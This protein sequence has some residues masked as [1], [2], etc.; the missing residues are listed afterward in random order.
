MNTVSRFR[1]CSRGVRPFSPTGMF[2]YTD[3]GGPGVGTSDSDAMVKAAAYRIRRREREKER[4]RAA[5][6]E[7]AR[8]WARD[9]AEHLGRTDPTLRKVIGF[10]STFETWRPYRL[11]SDVDLGIVGGDWGLLSRSIPA[12]EFGVSLVELELQNPEFKD[13]VLVHGVVLYEKS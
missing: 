11:N 4:A 9:V 1:D 13:Y 3:T 2:R 5:R 12:S 7:R 8:A 10:G 6:R